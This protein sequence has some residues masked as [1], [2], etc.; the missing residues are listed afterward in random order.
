MRAAA[1][2]LTRPPACGSTP[3]PWWTRD[4]SA[5]KVMQWRSGYASERRPRQILTIRS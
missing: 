3:P 5:K 2:P 4:V 1:A